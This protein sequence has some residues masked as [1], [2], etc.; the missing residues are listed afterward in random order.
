MRNVYQTP[1]HAKV[2]VLPDGCWQW[3]GLL[4]NDGYGDLVHNGRTRS[5]HRYFFELWDGSI[6]AGKHLHHICENRACV[7]PKHLMVVTQREHMA[8]SPRS[9]SYRNSQKTHCKRGHEFSGSNLMMIRTPHGWGRRCRICHRERARIYC[10]KKRSENPEA[11]NAKQ[12]RNYAKRR[13]G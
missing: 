6:P 4:D 1:H 13:K 7:N 10:A 11:V 9:P 5:A 12:R 3:Q 8:L 2:A